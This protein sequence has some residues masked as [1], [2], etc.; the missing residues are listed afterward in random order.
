MCPAN[1]QPQDQVSTTN[2][3]IG[4]GKSLG[5]FDAAVRY[6]AHDRTGHAVLFYG[7]DQAFIGSMIRFVSAALG[8]G[9][10]AIVIGTRP[11]LDKL[12]E[13]LESEGYDVGRL[14][15]QGRYAPLD[16]AQT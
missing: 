9:F 13:R 12:A 14:C 6:P 16:A 11:H 8:G 10:P 2:M 4:V 3:A 1:E 7:Q 5:S 15:Q